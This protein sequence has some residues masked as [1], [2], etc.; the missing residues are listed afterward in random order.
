MDAH[1]SLAKVQLL[2]YVQRQVECTMTSIVRLSNCII[3]VYA[4]GEHPPPH[5]HLRGPNSRCSVEIATLEILKGRGD[6]K[7]ARE[8]LAVPENCAALEA[9]W[10]RL[11]ERE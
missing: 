7:D 6:K 5:F 2:H 10:R 8:W 9:E 3:Y 1:L 4:R 11:N